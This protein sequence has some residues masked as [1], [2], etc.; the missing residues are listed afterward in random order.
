MQGDPVSPRFANRGEGLSMPQINQVRHASQRASAVIRSAPLPKVED[1]VVIERCCSLEFENP[2]TERRFSRW[3]LMENR[4]SLVFFL[5]LVLVESANILFI[6]TWS[7]WD[8]D[9]EVQNVQHG[10]LAVNV[11]ASPL[12]LIATT[13]SAVTMPLCVVILIIA[14]WGCHTEGTGTLRGRC[15]ACAASTLL[16]RCVGCVRY[17][18]F[19]QDDDDDANNA[20]SR[21]RSSTLRRL[22]AASASDANSSSGSGGDPD[23]DESA[24]A[25]KS[26]YSS[27]SSPTLT[28]REQI[29]TR[30]FCHRCIMRD[31]LFLSSG[32]PRVSMMEHGDGTTRA[33]DSAT[34]A[35]CRG[36]SRR[37]IP[38]RC[39]CVPFHE[40]VFLVLHICVAIRTSAR[41]AFTCL[42]AWQSYFLTSSSRSWIKMC[43]HLGANVTA[44][45]HD[46]KAIGLKHGRPDR[47]WGVAN[48][49]YTLLGTCAAD[50]DAMP[51]Q[52]SRLPSTQCALEVSYL[53]DVGG[54]VYLIKESLI[55]ATCEVAAVIFILMLLA[56]FRFGH[57]AAT[58]ATTVAIH[59]AITMISFYAWLD[60]TVGETFNFAVIQLGTATGVALLSI[61]GVRM[62]QLHA[63]YV[64]RC[65]MHGNRLATELVR[66]RNQLETQTARVFED[67]LSERSKP[68]WLIESGE[69]VLDGGGSIG[70]WGDL[71]GIV[72]S[73][74]FGGGSGDRAA[75]AAAA[76]AATQGHAGGAGAAGGGKG[77]GD[78]GAATLYK[79]VWRHVGV[80]AQRFATPQPDWVRLRAEMAILSRI[81]HPHIVLFLGATP[82]RT[83]LFVITEWMSNGTLRDCLANEAKRAE[84]RMMGF[85]SFTFCRY[86]ILYA[87]L[88]FFYNEYKF[89]PIILLSAH[90]HH[91]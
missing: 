51:A 66:S 78:G 7:P 57:F 27:G 14:T 3:L 74:S 33:V 38:R 53:S 46:V 21:W 88:H 36:S 23:D 12:M 61:Y 89:V 68:L 32:F 16:G 49:V 28:R 72:A 64:Y 8:G 58:V 10:T 80:T 79:G 48:L 17:G 84:W 19:V 2:E 42:H 4:Y 20:N 45:A 71:G 40:F 50:L 6:V 56:R 34:A 73:G 47:G 83:S 41:I 91:T 18:G 39:F 37:G 44:L 70:S 77:G 31:W 15:V 55:W 35:H 43:P 63:R 90:H 25:D 82:T 62:R 5:I 87:A 65:L 59:A 9:P 81:R 1:E 54:K 52:G 11:W 69:V 67:L 60:D 26:D 29:A 30:G 75:A 22:Q 76:A 24:T 86:R 13:V 85:V